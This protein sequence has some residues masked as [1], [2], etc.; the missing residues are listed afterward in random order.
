M[1]YLSLKFWWFFLSLCFFSQIQNNHVVCINGVT[2]ADYDDISGMWHY[3]CVCA[4]QYLNVP[5]TWFKKPSASW[6]SKCL[7]VSSLVFLVNS[8]L[9]YA[10]KC[11]CKPKKGCISV[12]PFLPVLPIFTK[13]CSAWA[14][15]SLLQALQCCGHTVFLPGQC[16]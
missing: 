10:I 11:V 12:V 2:Y 4:F 14:V 8:N 5:V 6:F 15:Q 3:L 13:P 9:S 16:H 7:E 1:L